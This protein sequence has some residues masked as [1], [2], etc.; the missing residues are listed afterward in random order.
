MQSSPTP[1]TTTSET[2]ARPRTG[3]G[4]QAAVLSIE[5]HIDPNFSIRK[6]TDPNYKDV[7]KAV[8]RRA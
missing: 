3:A 4:P 6:N 1:L 5:E 7:K 2:T 8:L